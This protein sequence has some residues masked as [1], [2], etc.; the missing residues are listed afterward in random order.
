MQKRQ[1]V[2]DKK[3]RQSQVSKK[4]NHFHSFNCGGIF[5]QESNIVT[6][7]GE[8]KANNQNNIPLRAQSP[9]MA[10]TDKC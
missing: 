4:Y 8:D 9:M 3:I 7:D 10:P 6:T 5:F 2:A 1:K